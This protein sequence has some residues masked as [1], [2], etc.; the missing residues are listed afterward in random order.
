VTDS[1]LLAEI[2]ENRNEIK[3]MQEQFYTFKG[4]ALGALSL[5]TVV[6]NIAFEYVIKK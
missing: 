5:L 2:R 6:I 1:E 3:K 4:R